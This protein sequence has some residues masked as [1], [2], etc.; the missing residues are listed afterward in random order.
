MTV[1]Y[2]TTA[3]RDPVALDAILTLGVAMRWNVL[4]PS[5]V[6]RGSATHGGPGSVAGGVAVAYRARALFLRHGPRDPTQILDD[7]FAVSFRLSG[8][9]PIMP[10]PAVTLDG[11][12]VRACAC[13]CAELSASQ[14]EGVHNV[15]YRTRQT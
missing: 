14:P 11:A 5:H 9:S 6:R 15:S 13:F 3:H 12:A 7:A 4:W 10:V 1:A 8:D 2:V